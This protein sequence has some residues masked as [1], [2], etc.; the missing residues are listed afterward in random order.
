[1]QKILKNVLKYVSMYVNIHTNIKG[2]DTLESK[3]KSDYG[4]LLVNLIKSK[5]MSQQM[6]Y[7]KLGITKPYFYDIISGKAN[8]PPP[9]MQLKIIDILK[10][11]ELEQKSLL[12]IAAIERKEMPADILVYFKK[13]N[14]I[15][16]K[17]R[18]SEEYKKI[19]IG[20]E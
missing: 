12:E 17:I 5:G 15:L 13:D 8:P 16:D 2:V 6:F 14:T 10:P 7:N 18:N 19:M 3:K 4:Y 20:G 1:M 9:E 11:T